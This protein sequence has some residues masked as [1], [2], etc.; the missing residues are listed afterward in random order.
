MLQQTL[1]LVYHV[2]IRQSESATAPEK[3][4][5]DSK[6]WEVGTTRIDLHKAKQSTFDRP[7][8]P[9]REVKALSKASSTTGLPCTTGGPGGELP[10]GWMK[11]SSTAAAS[12]AATY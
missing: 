8:M 12:N 10:I 4:Y 7:S 9:N 2:G 11:Y 5:S 1:Y 6:G 3:S